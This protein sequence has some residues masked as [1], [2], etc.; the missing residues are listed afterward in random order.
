ML[1]DHEGE[2]L[3]LSIPENPTNKK[4][5]TSPLKD[6]DFPEGV[7]VGG[8]IRGEDVSIPDGNFQLNAGDVL[9][10][11]ALAKSISQVE[12]LIR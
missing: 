11:V 4:L 2:I 1:G 7:L 5:I 6:Q 3:E 8:V 9:L 12:K 10:V